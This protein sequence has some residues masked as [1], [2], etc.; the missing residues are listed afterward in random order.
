MQPV[1]P[2]STVETEGN[3][4]FTFVQFFTDRQALVCVLRTFWKIGRKQR[5]RSEKSIP[6][7]LVKTKVN[8]VG[9]CAQ[10]FPARQWCWCF[11]GRRIL[12]SC[13]WQLYKAAE[14][15]YHR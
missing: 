11:M 15:S 1:S 9:L 12:H 14:S 13:F 7:E 2:P 4:T 3:N 10:R 8:V 6:Q 5:E